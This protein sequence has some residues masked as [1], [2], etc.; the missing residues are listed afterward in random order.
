MAITLPSDTRK[1]LIASLK[2]YAADNLDEEIGDLKAGAY[3]QERTSDLDGLC[4]QPELTYWRT[5]S[6]KSRQQQT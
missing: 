4:H 2:K 1:Q 5:L 6:G 3:V